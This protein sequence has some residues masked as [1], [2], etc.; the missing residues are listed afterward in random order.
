MSL[1]TKR[2]KGLRIKRKLEEAEVPKN[3]SHNEKTAVAMADNG[4]LSPEGRGLLAQG[5]G[6]GQWAGP[7]QL[8]REPV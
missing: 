8:C 7:G 6:R 1:I 4:S 2:G 5:R 3:K